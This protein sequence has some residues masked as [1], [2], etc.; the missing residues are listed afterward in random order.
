[1]LKDKSD[2]MLALAEDH[3]NDIASNLGAVGAAA[4]TAALPEAWWIDPVRCVES[5]AALGGGLDCV[6][7]G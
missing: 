5:R 2:S 7:D 1:V 3:L 6:S 4:A